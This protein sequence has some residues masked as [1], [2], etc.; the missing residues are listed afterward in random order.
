MP[1]GMYFLSFL[2]DAGFPNPKKAQNWA[3]K[4]EVQ[5]EKIEVMSPGKKDDLSHI[6]DTWLWW[7]IPNSLKYIDSNV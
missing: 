3:S 2:L 4:E 6:G 1:P 7:V 5:N